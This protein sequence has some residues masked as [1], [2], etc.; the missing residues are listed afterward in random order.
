MTRIF[1][2][3]LRSPLN[4][5]RMQMMTSNLSWLNNITCINVK[6]KESHL[7]AWTWLT[8]D[9]RLLRTEWWCSYPRQ[10][11][12]TIYQNLTTTQNIF[13]CLTLKQALADCFKVQISSSEESGKMEQ[14]KNLFC[15]ILVPRLIRQN[16]SNLQLFSFCEY[17]KETMMIPILQ[18]YILVLVTSTIKIY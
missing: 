7:P 10:L 2:L 5:Y 4:N 8:N 18:F 15:H 12:Y 1:R 3:H 14:R 11:F 13:F 17:V 6:I 9:F 16:V